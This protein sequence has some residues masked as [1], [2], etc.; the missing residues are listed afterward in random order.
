M[1]KSLLGQLLVKFILSPII[2]KFFDW[3]QWSFSELFRVKISR[4]RVNVFGINRKKKQN[5]NFLE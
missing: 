4:I 3:N 1:L 2:P 5:I